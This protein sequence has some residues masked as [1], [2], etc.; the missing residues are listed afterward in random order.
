VIYH[1]MP[2]PYKDRLH[3]EALP[4]SRHVAATLARCIGCLPVPPPIAK[5]PVGAHQSSHRLFCRRCV[6]SMFRASY[7]A[8]L[9]R[10]PAW[11]RMLPARR[12][13]YVV[14][15]AVGYDVRSVPRCVREECEGGTHLCSRRVVCMMSWVWGVLSDA[16]TGVVAGRLHVIVGASPGNK[17]SVW[18]RLPSFVEL[19]P[20]S[21]QLTVAPRMGCSVVR[22]PVPIRILGFLPASVPFFRFVLRAS[23]TFWLQVRLRTGF[24][25]R[26]VALGPA[27][28]AVRPREMAVGDAPRCPPSSPVQSAPMPLGNSAPVFRNETGA[29]TMAVCSATGEEY[30]HDGAVRFY[31]SKAE[32]MGWSQGWTV[33]P[34][35]FFWYHE[36]TGAYFQPEPRPQYRSPEAASTAAAA[37]GL[38]LELDRAPERAPS[39]LA[40]PSG[41]PPEST[42]SGPRGA[43]PAVRMFP[44]PSSRS[45]RGG[46]GADSVSLQSLAGSR[47]SSS[48]DRGPSAGCSP[49][50][51]GEEDEEEQ[52]RLRSATEEGTWHWTG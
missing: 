12:V 20:H 14:P 38:L 22:V 46:S 17:P 34:H 19:G 1:S 8:V 44:E 31:P 13:W 36:I 43:S 6:R 50:T 2:R 10:S 23:V 4:V 39:R 41:P 52:R 48:N 16:D 40:L 3:A 28:E 51:P 45:Q 21:Q 32:E 25:F 35:E 37:I 47:S 15:S 49:G 7:A 29:W 26:I 27:L 30:W 33:V 5:H 24:A 9:H 42:G 11:S 18:I